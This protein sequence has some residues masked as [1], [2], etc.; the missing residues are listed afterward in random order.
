MVENI[1]KEDFEKLLQQRD[2][3]IEKLK[4]LENKKGATKESIFKKV[5]SD[6][7]GRLNNIKEQLGKFSDFARERVKS[8]NENLEQLKTERESYADKIEELKLRFELGE[9][10]EGN[11]QE[12]VEE[13]EKMLNE[14]D[15]KLKKVEGEIASMKELLVGEEKDGATEERIEEVV[16]EE[17]VAEEETKEE[18]PSEELSEIFEEETKEG[19]QT[20]GGEEEGETVGVQEK[21]LEEAFKT[22]EEKP[23]GKEIAESLEASLEESLDD[24]LKEAEVPD[25][26]EKEETP[27]PEIIPEG[28]AVKKETSKLEGFTEET[29]ETTEEAEEEMPEGEESQAEEE[30]E[31]PEEGEEKVDGLVCPKCGYVNSKDSW[32]CEKCGAE[33]LQ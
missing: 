11:Y 24:L 20:E 19:V 14:V 17:A 16:T 4:K 1:N 18:M 28:E 30:G 8:L 32:Y 29:E 21:K 7:E 10:E 23:E 27:A 25:E 22:D 6:Y 5:K 9:Y 33:L 12:E 13:N 2:D 3:L 15:D 26:G 31:Q